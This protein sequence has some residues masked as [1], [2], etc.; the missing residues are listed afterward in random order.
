MTAPPSSADASAS[1]AVPAMDVCPLEPAAAVLRPRRTAVKCRGA[2][3]ASGGGAT[4]R[5]LRW[6]KDARAKTM[7]RLRNDEAAPRALT[8]ASTAADDDDR[9]LR[10]MF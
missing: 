6:N 5:K 1:P 8:P 2:A 10:S 4:P 9:A 7:V 3:G